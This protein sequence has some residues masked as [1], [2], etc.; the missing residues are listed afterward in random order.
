MFKSFHRDLHHNQL[1]K[2]IENS[3]VNDAIDN[4]A[5]DIRSGKEGVEDFLI[6]KYGGLENYI[7]H[8]QSGRITEEQQINV[9]KD[10]QDYKKAFTFENTKEKLKEMVSNY[11]NKYN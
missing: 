8:L 4:K 7:I 6:N 10:L 3:N 2:L 5:A 11:C 9:V 1:N